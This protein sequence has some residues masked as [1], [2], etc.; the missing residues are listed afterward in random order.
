MKNKSL[1]PSLHQYAGHLKHGLDLKPV[2]VINP[3]LTVV[4]N[5]LCLVTTMKL[6]WY[7]VLN[8][9]YLKR[10]NYIYVS[11]NYPNGHQHFKKLPLI[12]VFDLDLYQ[13]YINFFYKGVCSTPSYVW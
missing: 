5:C 6:M 7:I 10:V 13:Q 4:S 9:T 2:K 8:K 1:S 12:S 3:C 11:V